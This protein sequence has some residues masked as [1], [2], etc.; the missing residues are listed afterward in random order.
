M[1]LA[2]G[3]LDEAAGQYRAAL[4][5]NEARGQSG[6]AAYNR[7]QLGVVAQRQ[8]R[9]EDAR[10]M[11]RAAGEAARDMGDVGLQA[12][13]QHQLAS[14]ALATGDFMQAL[15]HNQ[16]ATRL[17]QQ[18]SDALAE[19]S[20]LYYRGLL[21]IRAGNLEAGR[22]TLAQVHAS[23]VALN[24]PEANKVATVLAGLGAEGGEAAAGLPDG[25]GRIDVTTSGM[26]EV[27]Q[28]IDVITDGARGIDFRPRAGSRVQVPD[29]DVVREAAEAVAAAAEDIDV[30]V[31]KGNL[32]GAVVDEL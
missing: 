28:A 29:I 24:S 9:Y 6:D 8:Q 7:Y 22:Q 16:E 31:I 30:V 25:P 17:A 1:A 15:E 14:L 10:E 32:V 27:A 26:L 13:V 3:D 21:E 23:F 2:H 20:A 11:Y 19:T 5:I 12:A 18:A 4:Q